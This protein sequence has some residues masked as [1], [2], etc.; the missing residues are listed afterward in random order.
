M[1][2]NNKTC[3]CCGKVYTFCTGCSQYDN[4]PRWKAIY[5]NETCKDIFI[6]VS[7]YLQKAISKEEAKSRLSK[8]DLSY[9][10]KLH[11]NIQNGIAEI[12]AEEKKEEILDIDSDID[13]KINANVKPEQNTTNKANTKMRYNNK[14]RK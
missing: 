3:I 4:E 13:G 8:C 9:K 6:I 14:R 2:M 11:K 12:L 5:H 10:D 7:D 1:K